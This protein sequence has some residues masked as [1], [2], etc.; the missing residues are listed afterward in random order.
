MRNILP[1]KIRLILKY[2]GRCAWGVLMGRR[3]S[4]T[5]DMFKDIC[6]DAKRIGA[7]EARAEVKADA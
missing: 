5:P 3:V 4:F 2:R 7:A 6:Q 1:P